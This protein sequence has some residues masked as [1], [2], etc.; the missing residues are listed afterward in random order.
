MKFIC[1]ID[2]QAKSVFNIPVFPLI[3]KSGFLYSN[4][5]HL[6]ILCC[7]FFEIYSVNCNARRS[8]NQH[9][10]TIFDI[11]L[12][13]IRARENK[14]ES[15]LSEH[16][17]SECSIIRTFP[18]KFPFFGYVSSCTLYNFLCSIEWLL[19]ITIWYEINNYRNNI[20]YN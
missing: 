2:K 18:S 3:K 19:I 15:L 17:L 8:D 5:L 20:R 7:N 14:V 1:R 4:I 13:L 6:L 10:N 12:T 11:F 9:G 16:S